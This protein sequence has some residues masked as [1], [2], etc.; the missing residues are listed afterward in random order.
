MD[1]RDTERDSQT[2]RDRLTAETLIKLQT[3]TGTDRQTHRQT[4]T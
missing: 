2:D 1:N 4:A 3:D